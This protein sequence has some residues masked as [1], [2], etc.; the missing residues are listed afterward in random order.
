MWW[1]GKG[2]HLTHASLAAFPVKDINIYHIS[3]FRDEIMITPQD[4]KIIKDKSNYPTLGR[5]SSSL[6]FIIPFK[7]LGKVSWYCCILKCRCNDSGPCFHGLY[8]RALVVL[9]MVMTTHEGLHL[10]AYWIKCRVFNG[11][12]SLARHTSCHYFNSLIISTVK[13]KMLTAISI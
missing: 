3:H 1:L 2:L 12:F 7:H 10:Q 13:L 4:G 9:E 11:Y 5:L 6:S 8:C